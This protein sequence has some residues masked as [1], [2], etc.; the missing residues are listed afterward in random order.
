MRKNHY[1]EEKMIDRIEEFMIEY[2]NQNPGE[3][4]YKFIRIA[5][6][7]FKLMNIR[8][9]TG[10]HWLK[11]LI[12]KHKNK[13]SREVVLMDF[14]EKKPTKKYIHDDTLDREEGKLRS[15]KKRIKYQGSQEYKRKISEEL[16]K[17][18]EGKIK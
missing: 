7:V 18:L 6:A 17:R 10:N 14:L 4:K 2:L 1:S 13:I 8:K 16:D 3:K 9:C 11:V 5:S 15:K 12:E